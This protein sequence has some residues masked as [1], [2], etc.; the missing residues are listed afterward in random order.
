MSNK[1][2]IKVFKWAVSKLQSE[3][4]SYASSKGNFK[5]GTNKCNLFVADAYKKG[6]NKTSPRHYSYGIIPRD[7][8][9]TASEIYD[10]GSSDILSGKIGDILAYKHDYSDATGHT[11][12]YTGNVKIKGYPSP[13]GFGTIGAGSFTI[14]YRDEKF[15]IEHGYTSPHILKVK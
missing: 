6:A 4:Y 15:L 9:A 7:T 1:D 8:P 13:N 10:E 14:N 5:Q 3:E 2:N 12:I 11:V